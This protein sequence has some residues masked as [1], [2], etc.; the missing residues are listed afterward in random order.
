VLRECP[1]H[2]LHAVDT[3]LAVLSATSN[4]NVRSAYREL[5]PDRIRHPHLTSAQR[6][7]IWQR[8]EGTWLTRRA[9]VLDRNGRLAALKKVEPDAFHAVMPVA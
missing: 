9:D 4:P 7:Q 8:M 3:V 6:L 1:Q 2:I 5:P